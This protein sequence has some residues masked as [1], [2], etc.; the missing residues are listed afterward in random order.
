MALQQVTVVS[1]SPA[2]RSIS[3]AD[4]RLA[5]LRRRSVPRRPLHRSRQKPQG[6]EA[7]TLENVVNQ[8][9][10]DVRSHILWQ[11][12]KK[13]K[14]YGYGDNGEETQPFKKRRLCIQLSPPIEDAREKNRYH[15]EP[16][17]VASNCLR[18]DQSKD[19]AARHHGEN[20][21]SDCASH[22]SGPLWVSLLAVSMCRFMAAITVRRRRTP[23]RAFTT[24]W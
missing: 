4:A 22:V 18:P 3:V 8:A 9:R 6:G 16:N 21:D 10:H 7:E 5:C 19:H 11:E 1:A 17:Q 15:G 23:H 12:Q 2:V 13:R 20:E 24:R 14:G